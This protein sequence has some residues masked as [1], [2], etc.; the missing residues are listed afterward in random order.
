MAKTVIED[1]YYEN[2]IDYFIV[3]SNIK[4]YREKAKLTQAKL[5][6]KS[7]LSAK[8]ISRLENNHYKGH[9]HVY[10]Q[11]AIALDITLYDLIGNE[12]NTENDFLN[13]LN[14]LTRN[15]TDNQKKM[16]L[17]NL[18]TIKNYDF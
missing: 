17:E 15:I 4:K 3:N 9:L 12:N 2:S 10:V 7:H 14:L 16:L 5:A 13:Q 11:I 18:K 6:E 8:Y 1:E